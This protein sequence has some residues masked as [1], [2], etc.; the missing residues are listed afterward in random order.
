L[1]R[2]LCTNGHIVRDLELETQNAINI[3]T[4]GWHKTL[5]NTE[6]LQDRSITTYVV[7]DQY[8]LFLC[9]CELVYVSGPF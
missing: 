2:F 5:A 9:I 4:I 8:E 7:T 6:V 3:Q 1:E